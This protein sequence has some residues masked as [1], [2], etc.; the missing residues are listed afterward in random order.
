MAYCVFSSFHRNNW[1]LSQNHGERQFSRMNILSKIK[2]FS[3]NEN[4]VDVIWREE[5]NYYSLA[6]WPKILKKNRLVGSS[7]SGGGKEVRETRRWNKEQAWNCYNSKGLSTELWP[8]TQL[9]FP[10][11]ILAQVPHGTNFRKG[12]SGS[13]SYFTHVTYKRWHKR[14]L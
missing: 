10:A 8:N 3:Y 13:L 7:V 2:I 14:P 4:I 12:L 11:L 9:L 6:K 1:E 5:A